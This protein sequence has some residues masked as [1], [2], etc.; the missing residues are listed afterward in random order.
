[1]G[2]ECRILLDSIN[3]SGDR[4]TTFQITY[5]RFV[6]CELMTHRVFS[7]NSSSSRAIPIEKMI[8][9]V[10]NDPV[11]PVYWGKNQRGMQATEELTGVVRERAIEKWLD[12]RDCAVDHAREMHLNCVHK[13]IVNRILEPWM[14]ITV[15]VSATRNIRR[16]FLTVI[17]LDLYIYL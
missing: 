11:I 13:Q 15:L 6:H 14:W 9:Q 16:V 2:Y 10:E 12:A 4:L 1:M 3:T 7:R 5:P 8:E 17:L